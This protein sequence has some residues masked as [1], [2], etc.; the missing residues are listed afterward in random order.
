MKIHK[1]LG[2]LMAPLF[3]GVLLFSGSAANAAASVVVVH[4]GDMQGWSFFLEGA[5]T[6]G[7]GEMVAG[8]GTPPLLSGSARLATPGATDGSALGKLGYDGVRLDEI[9]SLQ[10]STYRTAGDPA[11]AV[12]LQLNI[13][14]DV[15]DADDSWKGRLV[16]EPY[17]SETV[18]T[19][20]WQ[21]W[22]TLTQGGWWGTGAAISGTCSIASPCTWAQ[23]LAAFP[24]AGIHNS[25]G[26]VIFKAGSNWAGFDGNVDALTIGVNG[27]ETTYDFELDAP[28][29]DAPDVAITAP[30]DSD[31]LAGSVDIRGSVE[32][33]N[34]LR[35]NLVVRDASNATVAG[36]GVV[37]ESDSLTDELLYV[38][39]TTLVADGTYTI[40]LAA[41]DAFGNR[42]AGS[43][44]QISV[45]VDNSG[46]VVEITAPDDGD[47][48][49][50]T[51]DVRGSVEDANPS[52]YFAVVRD[53]SNN[54]VAGPGT[55]NEGDSF[56]DE[57]L[58]SWDT[59]LVPD[60]MY[61]I[62][63]EARDALDNK[64]ANSEQ[65]ITV[66][67]NNIIGPPTDRR[68]CLD[69]GWKTFNNPSFR[70]LSRCVAFVV[71]ADFSEPS[72]TWVR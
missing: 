61:T 14:D 64:D 70:S 32:D 27:N 29:F 10:Y 39:D 30:D 49:M 58:F 6:T 31:V 23:V 46:P 66:E 68:E 18:E 72:R 13:D 11:E 45:E 56:T 52:H 42:D 71:L 69:D 60:G 59:T 19:G 22:D 33:D 21:T 34:P 37:N 28:D 24:D 54:Q 25:L 43:E 51:V 40:F 44:N 1:K 67:V 26:A 7:E 63:L 36:P 5:G 35:Y 3:L 17:Y 12:A 48:L 55:V 57:M 8:P 16:F 20:E 4:P 38:W 50:G 2:W 47:V 62:H 41:R 65:M 9:T 15:T 53:A